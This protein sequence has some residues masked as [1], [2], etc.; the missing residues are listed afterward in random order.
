M[1]RL[2][3]RILNYDFP[4]ERQDRSVEVHAEEG[5][6]ASLVRDDFLVKRGMF[7]AEPLDRLRS[8]LD[9]VAARERKEQDLAPTAELYPRHLMDKHEEFIRLLFKHPPTLSVIRAVLGPAVMYRGLSARIS[10][11][12]ADNNWHFHQRVIP[13]PL[14][15]LFCM[16]QT[17]EALIYLDPADSRSGPLCVLPGSHRKVQEYL[18]PGDF[19]D[20]PGQVTLELQPGDCVFLHGLVWHRGLPA[21]AGAPVRRLLIL[22]FGPCWMKGSI[23]G[24]P[25]EN[26]LTRRLIQGA[27]QESLELL[28]LAGYM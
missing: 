9:E 17:M 22:G 26:G 1:H 19:E 10:H 8:A 20:R 13:R 3:Y 4:V 5:E 12:G 28:G 11:P 6:I 18:P 25:P 16:P 14:P 24:T 27:D 21:R 15:P 23:Y 2:K 7:G